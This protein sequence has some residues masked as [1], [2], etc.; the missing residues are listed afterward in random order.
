LNKPTAAHHRI[1][2]PSETGTRQEDQ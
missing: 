2:E 1:D